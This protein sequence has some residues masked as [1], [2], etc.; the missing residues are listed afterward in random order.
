LRE[1]LGHVGLTLI[2]LNG[3]KGQGTIGRELPEKVTTRALIGWVLFDRATTQP[4]YTLF[5]TFLFAPYFVNG[6]M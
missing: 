1:R 5:V 4:F 3:A 6:F 2:L